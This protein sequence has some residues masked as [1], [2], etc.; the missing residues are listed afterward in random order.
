LYVVLYSSEIWWSFSRW[1]YLLGA[2]WKLALYSTGFVAWYV[3]F[4]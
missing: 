3:F 2:N 1:V 4:E